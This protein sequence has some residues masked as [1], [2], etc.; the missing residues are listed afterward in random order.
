MFG[1]VQETP[2]NE[3]DAVL[4]AEPLRRRESVRPLDHRE[5]SRELRISTR[6]PAFCSITR[7]ERRGLEFV[8]R[9]VTDGVARINLG[10]SRRSCGSA[11][12]TRGATGASPATTSTRCGG[13]C[14]RIRPRTTSSAPARRGPSGS[15]ARSRSARSGSTIRTTSCSDQRFMRPAE[16]DLLVADATKAKDA[17]RVDA[18]GDLRAA[19]DA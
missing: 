17:A 3:N 18:E 11:I 9:K 12:S 4:P 15:C 13:C 19:R 16:V 5:L 14:S 6:C 2:Q 8:T 1:K 7:S 10:I